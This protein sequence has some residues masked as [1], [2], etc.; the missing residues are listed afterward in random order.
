MAMAQMTRFLRDTNFNGVNSQRRNSVTQ[1]NLTFLS[2]PLTALYKQRKANAGSTT[3]MAPNN[4]LSPSNDATA[5]RAA[6]KSFN[7]GVKVTSKAFIE[8]LQNLTV[9]SSA[10]VI[11]NFIFSIPATILNCIDRSFYKRFLSSSA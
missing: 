5:G 7:V 9:S 1:G 6:K 11:I 8:I 4:V 2:I 3:N 10:K